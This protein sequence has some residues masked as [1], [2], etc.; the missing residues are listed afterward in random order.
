LGFAGHFQ[1]DAMTDLSKIAGG[2]QGIGSPVVSTAGALGFGT[3]NVGTPAAPFSGILQSLVQQ[4][5]ALDQRAKDAVTGVLTGQGVEVH[6]AMI[7][8]QKA[9]MAFELALQVRNKAVG[10]Y[11]QMMQMQF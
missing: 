8:T 7:A 3:T 9:D 1:E 5:T 4:T 10:A 11:Q 2:V 6:D